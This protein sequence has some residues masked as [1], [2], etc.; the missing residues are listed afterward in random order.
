MKKT[1]LACLLLIVSTTALFAETI[2]VKVKGMVCSFCAQGLSKNF[3]EAPAVEKVTV[4]LKEK[5]IELDLKK[6]A[7]LSDESIKKIV[8]DAGYNVHSIK[9]K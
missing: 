5:T 3:K 6:D 7:T 1:L 9:R 4:L 2:D 8:M